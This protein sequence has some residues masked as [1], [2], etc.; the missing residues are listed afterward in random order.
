MQYQKQVAARQAQ[1]A[2]VAQ[3][4]ANATAHRR[5]QID[6]TRSARERASLAR[7][8]EREAHRQHEELMLAEAAAQ[9]RELA[10]ARTGMRSILASALDSD[11][12]VDLETLRAV[13][14]HPPFAHADLE[15]TLPAPQPL[16]SPPEPVYQEPPAPRGLNAVFGSKKHAQAVA[17][18]QEAFRERHEKWE[19]EVAALPITQFKQMEAYQTAEHQRI[20]KQ[21]TARQEYASECAEREAV[22]A[23]TNGA[24]DDLIQG[25]AGGRPEAVQEYSSMVLD[26][27]VYPDVFSVDH[28]C[29]YDA[30]LHELALTVT[31]P[32]PDSLAVEKEF[33]YNKAKDEVSAVPAPTRELK[34]GYTDAILMVALRTL[35]E[36]FAADRNGHLQTI[37]LRVQTSGTDPA[38]GLP[39]GPTLIAV[40]A[41][42]SRFLTFDL[43]KVVPLATL[44]LLGAQVSKSPFELVG[45]DASA[46]VRHH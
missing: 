1:Q 46:G 32:P 36:L 2:A 42:R 10:A 4:R 7:A 29:S 44:Q 6:A 19:S 12:S 22:I 5:A 20:T 17:L 26:K 27:S 34:E 23:R 11:P 43:A 21:A 15:Q 45:I 40:A 8:D 41:E 39:A 31:V 9:T 30:S 25:L 33:R 14:S 18:A 35:H 3:A 28:D 38:T 16:A 13:V 37:A 24:L